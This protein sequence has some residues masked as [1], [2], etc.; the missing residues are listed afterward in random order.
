MN[1]LTSFILAALLL[2]PMAA[3]Q[4][5]DNDDIMLISF[6]RENGTAGIY[7]AA[8]EDGL[9]FTPL[10]N[11][12]PVMKPG[13][14]AKQSLTRD[15][16]MVYHDGK[17]HAVWTTS[18]GGNCFGYAESTDLVHWSQPVQV[19]PFAGAQQP[20]ATWAP[21]ICW[22]PV[23]KNYMIFWSSEMVAKQGKR[24]FFTRTA[25]GKTFSEAKPF[26]DPGYTC[27]DGMMV[28][29]DNAA[30]K[31][32]VLVFKNEASEI[33]GGKNLHIA[34]TSADFSQPWTIYP[35]PVIGPGT[36]VHP[37][38]MCEGPSLLKTETGWN[39]YWDSPLIKTYAM[40]S[41]TDLINW[42]DHTAELQLPEHPRHGTVFRAPRSAVGWLQKSLSEK[43]P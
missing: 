4:A 15:P 36:K 9:H 18:W 22:D 34:T 5:A 25:D 26:L 30:E 40:A 10:N 43:K 23:Q 1:K 13:P 37:E 27:I 6:F 14:W 32:W 7:M 17:F 35:E 8:S 3:L 21:E 12:Q 33:N 2:A 29:D 31:R 16:S 20:L 41:S 39:L 38:S 42:M 19:V 28:F 11:D 24:I